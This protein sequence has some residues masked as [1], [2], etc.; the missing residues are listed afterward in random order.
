MMYWHCEALVA[1]SVYESNGEIARTRW[2]EAG[3][4]EYESY[5][6]EQRKRIMGV[7]WRHIVLRPGDHY[8]VVPC[9]S[10]SYDTFPDVSVL[11]K[12]RHA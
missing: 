1:P 10:G 11:Q 3:E 9:P 4:A 5:L 8:V 12:R 6:A 7:A 2:T